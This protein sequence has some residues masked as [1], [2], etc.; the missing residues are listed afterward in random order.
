MQKKIFTFAVL[1]S[2][3]ITFDYRKLL[4]ISVIYCKY[5]TLNHKRTNKD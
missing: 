2:Y 3:M 5:L 1:L 4:I